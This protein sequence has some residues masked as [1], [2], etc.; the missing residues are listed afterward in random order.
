MAVIGRLNE[1]GNVRL[2]FALSRKNVRSA[3]Q[4]N[5]IKRVVRESV[6]KHAA[7]LAGLDLVVVGRRGVADLENAALRR[8]LERHW[9]RL[10]DKR[11]AFVNQQGDR[12]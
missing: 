11:R 1:I 7:E 3:V 12:A 2:G 5:R 10:C 8:A 9:R 6:R 4:R